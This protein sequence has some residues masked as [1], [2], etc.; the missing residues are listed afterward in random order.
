MLGRELGLADHGTGIL[1][2]PEDAPL[3][4]L[5]RDYLELDDPCWN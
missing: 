5:L 4:E 2:L 3:G 1:E